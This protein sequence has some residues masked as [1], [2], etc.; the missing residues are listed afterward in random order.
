MPSAISSSLLGRNTCLATQLGGGVRAQERKGLLGNVSLGFFKR[1]RM[2]MSAVGRTH[3][4]FK[5]RIDEQV[6]AP[7]LPAAQLPKR[8]SFALC[9]AAQAALARRKHVLLG[10]RSS[11]C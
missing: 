11:P 1:K 7:I 5:F 6:A 10:H 2:G 8:E 3:R 4:R 9:N